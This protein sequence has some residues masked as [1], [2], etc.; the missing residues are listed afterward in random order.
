MRRMMKCE[1]RRC[2]NYEGREGDNED[3]RRGTKLNFYNVHI[4]KE[5]YPARSKSPNIQYS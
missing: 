3:R 5:K 2:K 1:E 4:S